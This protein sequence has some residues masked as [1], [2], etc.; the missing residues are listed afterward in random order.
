MRALALFAA[1]LG[2]ATASCIHTRETKSQE[3]AKADGK[4]EAKNDD[5]KK[6]P[7]AKKDAK[8]ADGPARPKA[9]VR[10]E[11]IE[12]SRT[13]KQMFKPEG[14][15]KLQVAL[16]AKSTGV[17]EN[18]QLDAKTQESLRAYQK[19]KGLPATGLPD[20]ETLRKLGLKPDDVFQ[21]DTPGE[22][23]GVQ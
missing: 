10:S 3:E 18:G 2:L 5:A 9:P 7:E 12:T 19:D 11:T 4:T 15:K 6:D 20:Y 8:A 1:C 23:N 13:T 22:R 17:D 16:A 21:K 14:L